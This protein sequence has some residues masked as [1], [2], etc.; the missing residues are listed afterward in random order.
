MDMSNH[1]KRIACIG[2][3]LIG[4]SW[5]ALFAL[6]GYPVIMQDSN[7]K[8][9]SNGLKG[10]HTILSTLKESGITDEKM[11]SRAR[12]RVK[13]TPSISEA[14]ENAEFVQ[15]SVFEDYEL[16]RRVFREMDKHA[17]E[18]AI[19]AS[20]S[21]GLLM[22]KIQTAVKKR[23][24]CLITHPFNPPHL[25]PLVEIVPGRW[26]STETVEKTYDF[27][28]KLGK[29][30][31]K[32]KQEIPGYVA[33]RLTAALWR[34][35]IDL[36]LRGAASAEDIDRACQFGPGMRW[37]VQGPFLTYH[38]AGGEAGIEHFV[39]H[40]TPSFESR[41]KSMATWKKL[42]SDARREIVRNVRQMPTIRNASFEKLSERRDRQLIELLRIQANARLGKKAS[43]STL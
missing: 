29:I 31:I 34:E 1:I 11:T 3:G 17:P 13:L 12:Q 10:F 40:L 14:A 28:S 27:M 26:T 5:A 32:L 42:D 4:R 24:R 9:L 8:A 37:A 20:S 16:K 2:T 35:S 19:L 15:E 22:S 41:W 7:S 38:L 6:K 43:R 18:Q 36:L 30:P 39:E 25:V 21:S 33:N 23:E